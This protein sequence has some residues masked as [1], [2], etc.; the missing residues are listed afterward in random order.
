MGTVTASKLTMGANDDLSFAIY[1]ERGALR[2]SLMQ[3]NFLYYYVG[4]D[5]TGNYG[6]LRGYRAIECVG[7][8]PT[9]GGI[10]PSPK[11]PSGWLQGHL[12]SMYNFLSSVATDTSSHP[13]FSD[14]A[15]VQAILEAGYESA[16]NGGF[17]MVDDYRTR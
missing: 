11:A 6:G 3:P 17:M 14:G 8:Y 1:G 7:R 15:Y 10:F 9:P 2:F 12:Q 13:D 16:Q 4:T 5:P